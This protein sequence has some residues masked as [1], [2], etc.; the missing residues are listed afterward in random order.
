MNTKLRY[1]YRDENNY[2]N[3]GTVIFSGMINPFLESRFRHSLDVGEFFIAEQIGVPELFFTKKSEADHPWHEF[4]AFEDTTE[5]V[6]DHR[7]IKEFIEE[8]ENTQ[9][10]PE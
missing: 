3:A 9:W 1:I 5:T 2:K 4:V 6:T 8:V 7:S 10:S